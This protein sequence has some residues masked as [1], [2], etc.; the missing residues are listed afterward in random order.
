MNNNATQQLIDRLFKAGG[1]FGFKK[2]RRHPTVMQ[3]LFGSKEGTDIID[4]EKTS[5]SIENAKLAIEKVINTGGEVLFVGTKDEIRSTVRDIVG[6]TGSPLIVNRWVG[7]TLTNFS[8][9]RKRIARLHDLIAQ[10]ESG[11][12]DRKYTKKERIVI[13][14]EMQKLNFNFGGIKKMD[15][16]P[17]LLV[18]VD[19]RHNSIAV[20]EATMLKI[21]VISIS[22][23]DNNLTGITYPIVVN[24]SLIGSVRTVLT[25]LAETYKTARANYVPPVEIKSAHE[26]ERGARRPFRERG[27]RSTV[28]ERRPF[29]ARKEGQ[30]T[31]PPRPQGGRPQTHRAP[32]EQR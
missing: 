3:Y 8:E 9:I 25:E 31:R 12:L 6:S 16:L 19:V 20:E 17:K 5:S 27:D 28:R 32:V 13:N 26:G 21:P 14:H 2:S 18:V 30:H 24:D 15:R 29:T 4:L 7:G 22:G 10:G 1:H 23:T 11:E